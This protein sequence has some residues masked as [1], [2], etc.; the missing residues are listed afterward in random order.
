M[1][2]TRSVLRCLSSHL[3]DPVFATIAIA[4]CVS[5]A[6]PP[7]DPTAA[8]AALQPEHHATPGRGLP[9]STVYRGIVSRMHEFQRCDDEAKST[10]SAPEGKLTVAFKIDPDGRVRDAV[11]AKSTVAP[12]EVECILNE[13][14][15]LS[16]PSATRP[17]GASFPFLFRRG[18]DH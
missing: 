1:T 3:G 7:D 5:C 8:T 6:R 9:A 2:T 15:Q 10:G 12:I 14:R 4:S 13:F 16:F 18:Q 17:T 11:A